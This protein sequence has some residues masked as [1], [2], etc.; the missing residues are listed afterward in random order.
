[1]AKKALVSDPTVRQ[2]GF[3]LPRRTWSLL[4][5]F[6]TNTGLCAAYLQKWF[7]TSSDKCQRCEQQKMVHRRIVPSDRVRWPRIDTP[8][9]SWW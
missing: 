4:N 8:S 6:R 9:R 2:P 3:E 1:M 5:R 7:L